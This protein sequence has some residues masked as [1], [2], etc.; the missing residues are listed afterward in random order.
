MFSGFRKSA[1]E[2]YYKKREI[3]AAGRIE[4]FLCV[5]VLFVFFILSRALCCTNDFSF[6]F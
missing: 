4:G 2:Q 3:R 6:Y 1:A 5:Y